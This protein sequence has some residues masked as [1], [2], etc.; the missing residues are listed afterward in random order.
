MPFTTQ[1]TCL[2]SIKFAHSVTSLKFISLNNYSKS[3]SHLKVCSRKDEHNRIEK[4]RKGKERKTKGA[5]K[6]TKQGT[7][8]EQKE[9]TEKG[10][11]RKRNR[12][13]QIMLHSCSWLFNYVLTFVLPCCSELLGSIQFRRRHW[14]VALIA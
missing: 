5:G 3:S 4:E 7:E 9:R 13:F 10:A 2:V 8:K 14:R 11:E 12:M 6:M 1:S